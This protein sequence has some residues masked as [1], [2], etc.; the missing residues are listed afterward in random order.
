MIKVNHIS[1]CFKKGSVEAVKDVSFEINSNEIFALLGP[2]G[3][4][5]TTTMRMLSTLL[6]PT[7]GEI[8]YDDISICGHEKEI[9]KKIGFLTNEIRLE[10]QLT[11]NELAEFYGML[12]G[13]EAEEREANKKELFDYFGITEYADRRYESFSTGMKQKTSIAICLLH[14]PDIIIF[15]EPT[16]GLDVLTQRLIEGYILKEKEKGKCIIISTHILDVV[17]KLADRVGVIVDGRTVFC[18]TC[19]EMM[20]SQNTDNLD[21]AFIKFYEE[22]HHESPIKE[23]KDKKKGFFHL[24]R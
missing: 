6:Q 8:F 20:S 17:R 2:N 13:M 10:G 11:P 15:D 24:K 18:G 14:N 4:G 12:Y 7:K 9:R 21:D 16:N 19:E 23:K 5:K 3:A 1:K 22:N